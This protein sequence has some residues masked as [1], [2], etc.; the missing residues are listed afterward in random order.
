MLA[1]VSLCLIWIL[2]GY[3][4]RS[5]FKIF[6]DDLRKRLSSW[7]RLRRDFFGHLLIE[8]LTASKMSWHLAVNFMFDLG[9]SAFFVE[10][11]FKPCR[12]KFV[13]PTINLAFLGIF[14]KVKLP[15]KFCLHSFEWVVT[16]N[17]FSFFSKPLS[18]R[19]NSCYSKL[20]QISN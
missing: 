3:S 7:E 2:Y 17:S 6:Y 8:S 14:I 13:Y 11:V 12:L 9:F 18:S 4:G 16:Q 20:F 19:I 1:W 15:A 10:V 5:F